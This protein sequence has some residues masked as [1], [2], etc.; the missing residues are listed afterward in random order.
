M[1]NITSLLE[2]MKVVYMHVQ[3]CIFTLTVSA[4]Q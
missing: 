2:V 3:V 1:N 4:L